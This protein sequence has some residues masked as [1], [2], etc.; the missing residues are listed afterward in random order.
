MDEYSVLCPLTEWVKTQVGQRHCYIW[1]WTTKA[2][3]G[4]MFWPSGVVLGGPLFVLRWTDACSVS[5]QYMSRNIKIKNCRFN[6]F[7]NIYRNG[8][9]FR[10]YS[11]GYSS[12]SQTFFCSFSFLICRYSSVKLFIVSQLLFQNSIFYVLK[13]CFPDF[14]SRDP[15]F[16]SHKTRHNL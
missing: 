7:R 4:S 9:N 16:K 15:Y 8:Q 13:Q 6:S 11:I 14:F 1:T 12:G 2:L 3:N 5:Q 10:K